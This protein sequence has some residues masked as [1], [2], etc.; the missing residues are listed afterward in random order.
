MKEKSHRDLPCFQLEIKSH[1]ARFCKQHAANVFQPSA[2]KRNSDVSELDSTV[3]SSVKVN[4]TIIKLTCTWMIMK[5]RIKTK[6][7]ENS[8]GDN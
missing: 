4:K 3:N 5:F 1:L 8:T 6:N 7:S 2:T